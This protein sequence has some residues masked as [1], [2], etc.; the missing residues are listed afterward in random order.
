MGGMA[1]WVVRLTCYLSV[2]VLSLIKG[3][4]FYIEQETLP[5]FHSTGWFQETDL[6]AISQSN[7]N[8]LRDLWKIDLV[9]TNLF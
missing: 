6:S 4:H 1:Q 5:S 2:V 7:S 3:S 9:Y 8:K